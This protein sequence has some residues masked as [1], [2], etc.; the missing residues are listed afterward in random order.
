[1]PKKIVI[2]GIGATTPLGGD[3]PTTWDALLAGVSGTHALTHPW[4]ET[5]EL[6]VK[7]AAEALV[8]PETVLDR[9][10]ARRLDPVSQLAVV[11]A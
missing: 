11:S 3:V 6:P 1:M 10:E 7:F 5:Y 4:V 8:R 9:P 2:T